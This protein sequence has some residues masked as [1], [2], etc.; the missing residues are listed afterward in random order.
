[1]S[2]YDVVFEPEYGPL[3]VDYRA[4]RFVPS[5]F[6]FSL[7]LDSECVFSSRVD[8]GE[9]D[10]VIH[11]FGDE[12]KR[13]IRDNSEIVLELP[14]EY[15]APMGFSLRDYPWE[16][17]PI[18]ARIGEGHDAYTI[19][20]SRNVLPGEVAVEGDRGWW[21]YVEVATANGIAAGWVPST[22]LSPIRRYEGPARL[23]ASD[24]MLGG[25]PIDESNNV[26]E[27]YP[28]GGGD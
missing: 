3:L 19:I 21:L 6:I 7:P 4:M 22:F 20:V 1:M 16:G 13:I 18:S 12:W 2:A 15:E 27:E 14:W 25:D 9:A 17:A 26:A 10:N 5:P 11:M 24:T 28:T 23:E 8:H